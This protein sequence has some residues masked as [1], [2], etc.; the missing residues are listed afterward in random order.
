MPM[1]FCLSARI[2]K[3]LTKVLVCWVLCKC[4]LLLLL[5]RLLMVRSYPGTFQNDTW[6][7]CMCCDVY[8]V[9]ALQIDDSNVA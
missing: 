7:F 4:S 3:A 2:K 6:L 9:Y 5:L 1:L 8:G